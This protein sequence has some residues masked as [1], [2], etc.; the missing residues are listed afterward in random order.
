MHEKL[1]TLAVAAALI[2][3]AVGTWLAYDKYSR[4][5]HVVT[6]VKDAAVRLTSVLQAQAGGAA[7]IDY[8]SHATAIEGYASTLRR[9]NTSSFTPLADAADDYLVTAREIARRSVD[10]RRARER[11]TASLPALGQHIRTDRGAAAWTG[12]AMKLKETLD[13]DFRD[14]RIAVDAYRSVLGSLLVSQANVSSRVEDLP[15][16]DDALVKRAAASVLDAY[17][18]AEQNAKQVA[19]LGRHAG[20]R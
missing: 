14:Y 13:R 4:R 1:R 12:E 10:I 8:E 16:I 11:L 6:M 15:L 2:V 20:R 5:N 17:A 9:M 7:P 19:E 3:L 18:A